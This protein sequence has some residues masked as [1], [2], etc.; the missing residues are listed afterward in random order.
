MSPPPSGG[1]AG[2][3]FPWSEA[4]PTGAKR[5]TAGL[6]LVAAAAGCAPA[7]PVAAAAEDRP[8]IF[9]TRTDPDFGEAAPELQALL[10]VTT[11]KPPGAQHFCIVGYREANGDEWAWV[12]WREGRR[13]IFWAG[14]GGPDDRRES[15]ARS[16]RSLDL[17]ADVVA[18]EAAVAGSSY[19]VTRRWVDTRLADCAA[20]G[21]HYVIGYPASGGD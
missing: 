11:P 21:S 2:S 14:R 17:D 8:A 18:S 12:H 13:M 9:D 3:I 5:I 15:I 20:R 6:L 10:S 4:L 1:L 7:G 16:Q 19:R